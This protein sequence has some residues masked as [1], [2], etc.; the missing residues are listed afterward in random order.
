MS[1]VFDKVWASVDLHMPL[2]DVAAFA[3]RAEQLGFDGIAVADAIHDGPMTAAAVAGATSRVAIRTSGLV[4]FAR[5]PYTTAVAAW[6]L[7][8]LS[9]G[10]FELGLGPLVRP[11]I[12]DRYSM[13]WGPPAPRM[14]EYVESLRAIFD[15]WQHGTPLHYEGEHYR[16]T[17]M[18]DYM[19]PPKLEHPDLRIVIAGIGPHMTAVAGELADA[20]NTHPTNSDPRFLREITLPN[21][22][23]GAARRGRDPG[24]V[25]IIVNAMCATGPDAAAV[26][27]SRE[28]A[29][30]LLAILYSTREYMHSLDLYGWRDVGERLRRMIREGRWGELA[31]EITDEM[32]DVLVPTGT[33]AELPA[34]L[35]ERYDGLAQEIGLPLGDPADDE[36]VARM[37]EECRG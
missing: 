20:I 36:A 17:R 33:Y 23:R 34:V 25:A 26:A 24:E 11:I 1:P 21:L 29:R 28:G 15:C 7:Q 22:T 10:R 30:G 37:V 16:F 35:H 6:D 8:A 18:Q 3:R 31:P 13:A 19:K 32:L 27:R 14:R 12:V 4:A 2:A 5:S 9:G